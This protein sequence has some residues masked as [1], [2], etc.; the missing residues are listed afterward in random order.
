M[1]LPL[2]PSSD[3]DMNKVE[4]LHLDGAQD[5]AVA[6]E[7]YDSLMAQVEQLEET[8]EA[9]VVVNDSVNK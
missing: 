8:L 2:I 7:A 3:E 6:E 4:H 9:A 5:L 1:E